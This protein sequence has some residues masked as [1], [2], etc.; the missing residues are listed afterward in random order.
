MS[1]ISILLLGDSL[2]EGYTQSGQVYHSYGIQLKKRFEE[3]GKDVEVTQNKISFLTP[4]L[5]TRK[6]NFY[7]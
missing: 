5:F 7:R 3:A 4:S 2:T 6:F 1:S